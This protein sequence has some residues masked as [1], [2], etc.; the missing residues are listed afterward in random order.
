MDTNVSNVRFGNYSIGNSNA[1][2]LKGEQKPAEEKS[3]ET[4]QNQNVFINP[5][6]AMDVLAAQGMMNMA[7]I[8]LVSK[9][10]EKPF[11]PS[12]FLKDAEEVMGYEVSKYVAKDR[13]VD[14]EAAMVGT[15][16]PEVYKLADG[17]KDE[18]PLSPAN[19]L[20]LAAH[21]FAEE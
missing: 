9:N 19:R 18:V 10:E 2:Q 11:N 15:Y 21:I 14:I 17:I 7:Q 4:K 5:D 12:T 16:E 13:M 20:A 3:A 8:E 1:R 6:K